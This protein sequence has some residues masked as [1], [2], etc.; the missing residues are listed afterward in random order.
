M[1]PAMHSV[2]A[3]VV[4]QAR[5]C[6]HATLWACVSAGRYHD[7]TQVRISAMVHA[8]L[9]WMELSLGMADLIVRDEKL[10]DLTVIV[11]TNVRR[12]VHDAPQ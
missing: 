8:S 9:N 10:K 1:G 4:H 3:D 11:Y 2:S 6:F 12:S 7:I 5:A